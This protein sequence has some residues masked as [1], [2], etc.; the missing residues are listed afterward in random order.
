ML[1]LHVDYAHQ[2]SFPGS[3]SGV[4]YTVENQLSFPLTILQNLHGFHTLNNF[5]TASE[6]RIRRCN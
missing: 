6:D 3:Q 1:F 2:F 4:V 5:T